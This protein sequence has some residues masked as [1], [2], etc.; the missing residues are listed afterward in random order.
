MRLTLASLAAGFATYRPALTAQLA[1]VKMAT[2]QRF[3][4][5]VAY[6]ANCLDGHGEFMSPETVEKMAWDWM[7]DYREVGILHAAGTVGHGD[8]VESYIYR[9]PD[10][11]IADQVIKAGD[12]MLG[13]RWDAPGWAL[14]K[15]GRLEGWSIDGK[16]ARR[17][18]PRSIAGV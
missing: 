15:S 4:L 9:G 3:T 1:V 2:P 12:W 8:P 10:W 16:A 6:P 13:Y 5:G 17:P 11:E 7:A 14:I 18:V